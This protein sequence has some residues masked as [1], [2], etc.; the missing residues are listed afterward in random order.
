MSFVRKRRKYEYTYILLILKK[1]TADK[2]KQ[3][4]VIANR[5]PGIEGTRM[6]DFFECTS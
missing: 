6:K 5:K 2:P 4:Q 3:T 1:M